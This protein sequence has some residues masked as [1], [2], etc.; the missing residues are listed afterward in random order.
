MTRHTALKWMIFSAGVAASAAVTATRA[1][2]PWD[3]VAAAAG[4]LLS[5]AT[6]LCAAVAW[7]QRQR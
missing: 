4:A 3:I 1:A 2:Q 7:S 6:V 5:G